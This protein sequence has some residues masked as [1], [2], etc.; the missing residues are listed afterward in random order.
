MRRNG[1][2][3]GAKFDLKFDFSVPYFLYIE[4]LWQLDNDFMYF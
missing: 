1:Y 4:K 3:T 2:K